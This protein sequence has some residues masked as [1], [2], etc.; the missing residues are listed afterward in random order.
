MSKGKK[1]DYGGDPFSIVQVPVFDSMDKATR[2]HV[3]IFASFV[4]WKDYFENLLS[5]DFAISLVLENDCGGQATYEVRGPTSEFVGHGDHHDSKFTYLEKTESLEELLAKEE[6]Q[7]ERIR[8]NQEWCSY[9]VKVYPTQQMADQMLT[10]WPLYMA[11]GVIGI[12]VFTVLMFV[13]YDRLVELRQRLVLNT[14]EKSTAIVSSLFPKKIQERLM[15]EQG[16]SSGFKKGVF[17]SEKDRVKSFL[18]GG[19]IDDE[20]ELDTKP[21]ADL[22][23]HATVLFADMTGTYRLVNH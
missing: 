15:A 22:F 1:T 5:E 13:I 16:S 9:S 12:F 19:S 21:I 14:A 4:Q 20:D 11:L 18:S 7:K 6:L 8:I 17:S 23:P 2:K 3:A 10:S